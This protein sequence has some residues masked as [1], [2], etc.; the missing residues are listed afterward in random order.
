MS[1]KSY[2]FNAELVG[3][4]YDRVYNAE[5]VTSYLD[6]IIGNGVFPDPSTQLQVRAGTGMQVI[7]AEGQGWI[8]GHKMINSADYP[9]S[10]DGSDLT[11]D[12]ID[13]I[14]FYVDLLNRDMG[15]KAVKGTASASPSPKAPVHSVTYWELVLAQVLV[16]H[17][18]T[19]IT[20]EM[21]TDTRG[22]GTL[23]GY[24]QGLIQQIDTT[25]LWQQ[26]QAQFA[27]WMAS[28]QG[29]FEDFKQFSRKE[30]SVTTSAANESTFAVSTLIPEYADQYDTLDIYVNGFHL[31][32]SEYTESSGT[33]TLTTPI[34]AIG[35]T[36]DFIVLH[37]ED[38][39]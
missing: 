22:N 8:N 39:A 29:Q 12:R 24:V 1:I 34:A 13:T 2:F 23:C 38:P 35:T 21:I 11:L 5:D 37:L 16:A 27:A 19:Q 15:I 17:Q 36:V 10:L 7:V 9:I 18:T 4:S 32:A 14:V 20:A 26:Q 28:V 33:V 3:G 6:K 30:A 25:T 31:S